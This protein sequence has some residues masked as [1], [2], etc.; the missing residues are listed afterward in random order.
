MQKRGIGNHLK[1]FSPIAPHVAWRADFTHIIF[2][3]VHLYLA[4]ILDAYTKQILGYALSLHHTQEFVL[5]ALQNA[6]KNTGKIPE[7]FHSDQGSE[8]RSF[9][10]MQYLLENNITPSMS[11]K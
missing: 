10:M 5:Q 9:L 6:I 2:H 7:Y 3:G 11:R 4:T 1:N 8:Y